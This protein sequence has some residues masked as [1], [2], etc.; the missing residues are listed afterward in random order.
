MRLGQAA[1]EALRAEITGCLQPGDELAVVCP[2]GLKGTSIIAEQKKERLA[3][4]FSA[5]FIYNCRTLFRD[6]GAGETVSVKDSTVWKMAQEAGASSLYAMKEGG[7]LS[8]LW[9]M[10]EASQVGLTVDFRKVPIRQETIEV[11]E[12]FDINPYRLESEGSVLLGIRGG[13]ELVQKLRQE[14]Y[15]SEIIGQTNDG[16]DRLL[17]SGSGVRYL[18]RPGEDELYKIKML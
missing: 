16:N 6:Y 4:Q 9:K 11:C 15:M 5:G 10:A 3:E 17:Y 7:F 1:M 8:A 14:G 12:I 2:V 18:E 13:Q